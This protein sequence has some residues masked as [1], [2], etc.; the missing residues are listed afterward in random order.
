MNIVNPVKAEL[1][2]RIDVRARLL[3]SLMKHSVVESNGCWKW[4]GMKSEKGY[5]R[6]SLK[7]DGKV[8]IFKAHRVSYEIH[9]GP[10]PHDRM[11]DHL[12]RQPDCINADHM[13]IVDD[14]TNKLRGESLW[15]RE[16]RRT[17]CP[18]GHPYDEDNTYRWGGMRY[19]L[20][21]RKL[22]YLKRVA[23]RKEALQ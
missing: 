1:S 5:G 16:A 19:C 15:A 13:E 18:S 23:K 11:P 22:Q 20:T 3:F 7:I 12:C 14:V 10:I 9:K 21:C 2:R 8:Y 6:I 4:T 17:H